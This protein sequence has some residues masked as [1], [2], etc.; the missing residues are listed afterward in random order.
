MGTESMQVDNTHIKMDTKE[1]PFVGYRISIVGNITTQSSSND[2]EEAKE[3][4]RQVEE[5][6]KDEEKRK[7]QEEEERNK[8]TKEV[9][10]LKQKWKI[11]MQ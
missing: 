1:N 11:V 5:K 4:K 6:K 7:R 9:Y 8:K 3:K 10:E 2:E